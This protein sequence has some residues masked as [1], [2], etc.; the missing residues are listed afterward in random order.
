MRVS[1]SALAILTSVILFPE[2]AILLHDL[3]VFITAQFCV[4]LRISACS[5]FSSSGCARS[6]PPELWRVVPVVSLPH[7]CRFS[8]MWIAP[9][10]HRVLARD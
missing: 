3:G 6:S 9:Q 10:V 5:A 4:R 2:R 7:D 8:V 1:V